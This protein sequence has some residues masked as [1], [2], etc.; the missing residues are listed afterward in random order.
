MGV[1]QAKLIPSWL[2][3]LC[4]LCIAGDEPGASGIL[5]LAPSPSLGA[6]RRV[7]YL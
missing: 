6:T 4:S 2:I 1:S 3:F 5:R 7:L